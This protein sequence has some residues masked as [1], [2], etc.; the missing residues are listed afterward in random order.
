MY[1]HFNIWVNHIPVVFYLYTMTNNCKNHYHFTSMHFL[2]AKR[3]P[4]EMCSWVC[5]LL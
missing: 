2:Y 4:K 1:S 5:L 3:T